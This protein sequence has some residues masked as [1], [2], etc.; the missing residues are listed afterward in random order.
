MKF[1]KATTLPILG[2]LILGIFILLSYL[3]GAIFLDRILICSLILS[4]IFINK[5][6]ESYHA[7]ASNEEERTSKVN[8]FRRTQ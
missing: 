7:S 8:V 6:R 3:N 1:S 5:I 4:V 2:M